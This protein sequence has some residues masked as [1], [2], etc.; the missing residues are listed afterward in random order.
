LERAWSRQVCGLIPGFFFTHTCMVSCSVLDS[1]VYNNSSSFCSQNRI[2]CL[3]P[4]LNSFSVCLSLP[5]AF[6]SDLLLKLWEGA[7][8][9]VGFYIE[10]IMMYVVCTPTHPLSGAD[11]VSGLG[12]VA[13]YCYSSPWMWQW[14]GTLREWLSHKVS[15]LHSVSC[16]LQNVC[17]GNLFTI[18]SKVS[19]LHSVSCYLQNVCRGNLFTIS[20]KVSW[21]HSVSCYLQNVCCGNLFTISLKV[22]WLQLVVMLPSNVCCADFFSLKVSWL[23]LIVKC[24]TFKCLL[25]RFLYNF[26]DGLMTAPHCQMCYLQMLVVQISL[27]SHRRSHDCTSLSN[28]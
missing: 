11:E 18:S 2:V 5:S 16:Y 19:W 28:V 6:D 7:T 8:M 15:W 10:L 20:S 26:I 3:I 23:H 14:S 9:D 13:C 27:Q 1:I 12:M 22:S 17:R 24:V 21:L 4:N 25:C